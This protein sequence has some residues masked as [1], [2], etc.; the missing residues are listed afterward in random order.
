MRRRHPAQ[1]SDDVPSYPVT[2]CDVL[3]HQ[4]KTG[5]A[6]RAGRTVA[7]ADFKLTH[8]DLPAHLPAWGVLVLGPRLGER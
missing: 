2:A 7:M 4:A 1:A 5:F 3:G 8:R 6:I